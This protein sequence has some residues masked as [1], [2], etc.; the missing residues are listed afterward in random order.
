MRAPLN[1]TPHILR[2]DHAEKEKAFR[3]PG[4]SLLLSDSV[5]K[6]GIFSVLPSKEDQVQICIPHPQV[7]PEQLPLAQTM[8]QREKLTCHKHD[9]CFLKWITRV[10]GMRQ[11]GKLSWLSG[12]AHDL[13]TEGPRFHPWYRQIALRRKLEIYCQSEQT[14]P[15]WINLTQPVPDVQSC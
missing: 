7:T 12:K 4:K 10:G 6:L 1:L 2:S 13:P 14:M 11:L 3:K 15:E 5:S 8:R 9:I